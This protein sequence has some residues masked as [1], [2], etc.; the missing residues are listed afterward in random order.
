MMARN[1]A[2]SV[3]RFLIGTAVLT[4]LW[5]IAEST[6]LYARSPSCPDDATAIAPGASIQAAVERGGSGAIFCLRKGLHRAQAVRPLPKQRFYGEGET[7]LNGSRLLTDFKR[8]GAY[9][10]ASSQLQPRPKHGECLAEA[11]S[12]DQPDMVFIDDKP[13]TRVTQKSALISGSFYIDDAGGSIYLL[14]SPEKHKIEVTVASFAFESAAADVSINNITVE[15]YA[16]PAQKGAIHAREGARWTI[17]NCEVRL[18]S[19][20]GISVGTG[21]RVRNCDIH[22]NG[23]IGIEGSGTDIH[24]EDNRIWQNNTHGFDARWEAGGAKIAV[25]NGVIFRRNHVYNNNGPGLWCDI[26]CHNVVYEENRVENNRDIGIFH[27]ISFKAIIRKNVLTHNGLGD[28]GWFWGSDIVIAASQDVE[29][30]DNTLTVA[31]GRCGIMLID[32]G[33]RGEGGKTYKTRDNIIRDN[34]IKFDGIPCSGGVSDTKRGD[35]NF[36]IIA[37]GNNRFDGNTY[38]V[39]QASEASRFVWDQDITD[40]AGFRRKGLE[41]SGHLIPF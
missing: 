3:R 23:Q 8:E 40:W 13:L 5:I 22:H 27:E 30:S 34:Q 31:P 17:E 12:C 10:V 16:S 1:R 41:R 11:P 7:V 2:A 29:V 19:G 18:N 4:G 28:R 25:S 14:D 33:R 21:S 15:K 32:Q 20:A 26:D 36:A 38:R 35:E 9:W 24:I 39:A 37:T 6:Y